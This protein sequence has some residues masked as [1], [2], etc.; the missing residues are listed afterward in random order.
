[1]PPCGAQ[2]PPWQF[3]EQQSASLPH[4]FP[5]VTQP[6]ITTAVHT[7]AVH[8]PEQQSAASTHI[9]PFAAHCGPHL[10]AT[11]RTLQQSVGFTHAS[12]CDAHTFGGA[13]HTFDIWS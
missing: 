2:R 7:P 9:A 10:P 4:L 8:V 11:Q 3:C 1:M 5:S 12:P 6:P 13:T